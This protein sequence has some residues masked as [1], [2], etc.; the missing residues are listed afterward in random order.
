MGLP[1]CGLSFILELLSVLGDAGGAVL[2]F[3]QV[4]IPTAFFICALFVCLAQIRRRITHVVEAMQRALIFVQ[5]A[6]V[7]RF[8]V[9]SILKQENVLRSGCKIFCDL[10]AWSCVDL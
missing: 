2:L 3:L 8:F 6:P 1:T 4:Q 7:T 5:R 10:Y 9:R